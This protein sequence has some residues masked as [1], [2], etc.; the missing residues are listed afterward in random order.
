M[1]MAYNLPYK[2]II[3]FY[4]CTEKLKIQIYYGKSI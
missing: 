2:H 1:K 3:F 4:F